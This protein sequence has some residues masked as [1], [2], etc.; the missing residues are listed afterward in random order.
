MRLL[1]I[2]LIISFTALCQEQKPLELK[3]NSKD[4][5]K[6]EQIKVEKKKYEEAVRQFQILEAIEATIIESQFNNKDIPVPQRKEFT[7]GKIL[8]LKDEEK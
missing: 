5:L 2:L 6:L 1:F 8:Y 3:V 7:G 4:S